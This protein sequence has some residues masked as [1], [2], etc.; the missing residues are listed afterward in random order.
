[1]LIA[2]VRRRSTEAAPPL[3]PPMAMAGF[4]SA[5][6][7]TLHERG[8]CWWAEVR[9]CHSCVTCWTFQLRVITISAGSWPSHWPSSGHCGHCP[10]GGQGYCACSAESSLSPVTSVSPVQLL[11][12]LALLLSSGR[13]QVCSRKLIT[14]SVVSAAINTSLWSQCS[15]L[16][17]LRA[18]CHW[19]LWPLAAASVFS[20]P[21]AGAQPGQ[22]T[23][24]QHSHREC[25]QFTITLG[26]QIITL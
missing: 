3:R 23:R 7:R 17:S 14:V 12:L 10:S 4:T 25:H 24:Q 11:S 1:M 21:E 22:A 6:V 16:M 20:R 15:V 26:H 18:V 8:C 19:S 5:R 9:W 13:C 2:R